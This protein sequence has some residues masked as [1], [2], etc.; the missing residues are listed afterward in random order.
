VNLDM[1]GSPN[2]VPGVYSDGEPEL[3]ALLRRVHPGEEIGVLT[4]NRSDHSAFERAGVPVNGLYTGANERGPG[5]RPRDP[6]YHLPCDTLANV[7]REVLLRMARATALAL[8]RLT[9][10]QAK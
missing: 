3:G 4:G 1:V 7:D 8:V 2:A 9:G 6:C 10:A 5:G